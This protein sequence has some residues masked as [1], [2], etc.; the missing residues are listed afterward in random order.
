MVQTTYKKKSPKKKP[1]STRRRTNE[2]I[3]DTLE[4]FEISAGE[5]QHFLSVMSAD[6]DTTDPGWIQSSCSEGADGVGGGYILDALNHRQHPDTIDEWNYSNISPRTAV[7]HFLTIIYNGLDM[8]RHMETTEKL[9]RTITYTHNGKTFSRYVQ[10]GDTT[11]TGRK[12]ARRSIC[13]YVLYEYRPAT[14]DV[15]TQILCAVPTNGRRNG[16]QPVTE[17][18]SGDSPGVR[19]LDEV[20]RQGK[21]CGATHSRLDAVDTA[22]GFYDRHWCY[23]HDTLYYSGACTYSSHK[24]K[25]PTTQTGLWPMTI[26]LKGNTKANRCGHSKRVKNILDDENA[27]RSE[28]YQLFAQAVTKARVKEERMYLKDDIAY[29][30][31]VIKG[32]KKRAR[33]ATG[34]LAN[35]KTAVTTRQRTTNNQ[36]KRVEQLQKLLGNK[37]IRRSDVKRL[38]L[39]SIL[40][41]HE[42]ELARQK[43]EL[44]ASKYN[45]AKETALLKDSAK[46]QTQAEKIKLSKMK[47]KKDKL[48]DDYQ[49]GEYILKQRRK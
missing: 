33:N 38:R 14:K 11:M 34:S 21:L 29:Y 17:N 28:A 1:R 5:G 43:T 49:D 32:E 44:K 8:E 22:V 48:D 3:C 16:L 46:P 7:R 12:G 2:N 42:A 18:L 20:H 19:L 24:Q 30:N 41:T 9:T 40:Q 27:I 13:G 10:A 25:L 31:Q 26:C 23:R 45:L 39:N 4:T 36:Q 15:Y 6:N 35:L 37:K 47:K